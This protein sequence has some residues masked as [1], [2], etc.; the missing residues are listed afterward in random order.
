VCRIEGKK[1]KTKKKGCRH[2]P[3]SRKNLLSDISEKIFRSLPLAYFY[4]NCCAQDVRI[5]SAK[6]VDIKYNTRQW[7]TSL[8][9]K[10]ASKKLEYSV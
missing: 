7:P 5:T 9:I 6:E 1:K 4:G 3:S 10:T 2:I 8:L